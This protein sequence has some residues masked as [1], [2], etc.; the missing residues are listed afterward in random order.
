MNDL[1]DYEHGEILEYPEIYCTGAPDKKIRKN[2][3]NNHGYDDERGD[4]NVVADTLCSCVDDRDGLLI[5]L[6]LV[7]CRH[8]VEVAT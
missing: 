2:V 4:F 1:S 5:L 8:I 6:L 7:P 3:G